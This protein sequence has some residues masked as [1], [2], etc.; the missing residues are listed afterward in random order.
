[1]KIS[2]LIAKLQEIRDE[3][4]DIEVYVRKEDW[5]GTEYCEPSL[6][7][8]SEYSR[9]RTRGEMNPNVENELM[10]D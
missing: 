6:T 2:D 5:A 3:Q 10:I 7:V 1:M 9:E 8:T 4:G